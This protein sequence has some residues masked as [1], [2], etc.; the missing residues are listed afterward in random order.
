MKIIRMIMDPQIL[1]LISFGILLIGKVMFHQDYLNCF[2][3]IKGHIECFR[4]SNGKLSRMSLVLY[5]FVPFLISISL[6][7]V[8]CLDDGVV[9]LVTVIVSILTSMFF[10]LLTLILDMR[11]RI[12]VDTKYNAGDAYLSTKLLKETY[13]SIMFEIFISVLILIMCFVEL[14][15]KRYSLFSSLIIY[16]LVFVMLMNLFMILKRIYNVIKRDLEV[17]E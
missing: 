15:E 11:K 8:R 7:Q 1:L 10:T 16:Y 3:I 17:Y 13:Y 14:F 2:G 12:K 5:F 9:N 6:I 4:G